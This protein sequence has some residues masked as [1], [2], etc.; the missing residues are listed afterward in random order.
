[1]KN[2]ILRL[3]KTFAEKEFST[4]AGKFNFIFGVILAFCFIGI[5]LTE[6]VKKIIYYWIFHIVP[7]SHLYKLFW[8]LI[9]YGI[10][11]TIILYFIEVNKK[12]M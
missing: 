8:G 9:V 10:C 5:E 11:C 12:R 6:G 2:K 7:E 3:L 4:Q 1:M